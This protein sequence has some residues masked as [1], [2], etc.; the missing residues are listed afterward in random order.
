MMRASLAGSPY[1]LVFNNKFNEYT[2]DITD[3]I[4]ESVIAELRTS[5]EMIEKTPQEYD[6]S[7]VFI[8][9]GHDEAA[10]LDVARFIEK[11]GLSAIILHE[12]ANAGNTIIEK[13][14]EHAN[15]GF[16]IVLYTACDIGGK[17]ENNLKSRARQNVVFE[18]GFFIGKLGRKRVCAL[19]KDD[20]ETPSDIN[21]VVYIPLDPYNGWKTKIAKELESAGYTID[22]NR[23]HKS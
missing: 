12:Q 19:V 1:H 20:V 4:F 13:I 7:N 17:S 9:H 15:V 23:I 10:K 16:V 11:L 6:S 22:M 2:Q 5:E 18:H 21:G 3:S 14:E 8:V